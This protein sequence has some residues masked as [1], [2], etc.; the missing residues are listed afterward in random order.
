MNVATWVFLTWALAAPAVADDPC[1]TATA[2]VTI[3]DLTVEEDVVTARGTWQA[4]GGA[5]G[6]LLEYRVNNDR[7]RAETRSGTSGSWSVVRM[8]PQ[9]EGCGQRALRMF[10]F[11][12]VQDGERQLHCLKR[13]SSTPRHFEIS[14]APIAEIVDCTWKCSG[15]ND[16]SCTGACAATARRGTPGYVPYWGVNGEG[17]QNAEAAAEG[18]WSQPVTCK[19]GERISFKVRDRRSRWSNVDEMGCGVTE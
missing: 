18:P 2:A 7:L 14:C 10:V 15:G 1:S 4:G 13:S 9:E 6:V 19:I 12:S 8:D 17:W 11:P 16:G 5:S 3:D